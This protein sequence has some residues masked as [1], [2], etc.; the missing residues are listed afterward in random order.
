MV[1]HMHHPHPFLIPPSDSSISASRWE[2]A[3]EKFLELF[4]GKAPGLAHSDRTPLH[5]NQLDR[6]VKVSFDLAATILHDVTAPSSAASRDPRVPER[7]PSGRIVRPRTAELSREQRDRLNEFRELDEM[8]FIRPGTGGLRQGSANGRLWSQSSQYGDVVFPRTKRPLSRETK[9]LVFSILGDSFRCGLVPLIRGT[10][11]DATDKI[12][13]Q[14][15][16]HKQKLELEGVHHHLKHGVA[17]AAGPGLVDISINRG[18]NVFGVARSEVPARIPPNLTG[19]GV[20]KEYVDEGARRIIARNIVRRYQL[21]KLPQ[22]IRRMTPSPSKVGSLALEDGVERQFVRLSD[23]EG[24]SDR[25]MESDNEETRLQADKT[26]LR[27]RIDTSQIPQT[28]LFDFLGDMEE[29][30]AALGVTRADRQ[31]MQFQALQNGEQSDRLRTKGISV[32]HVFPLDYFMDEEDV[33]MI[34]SDLASRSSEEKLGYRAVMV[35]QDPNWVEIISHFLEL[36][37]T[38]CVVQDFDATTR[39]F[40]VKWDS[41]PR[42]PRGAADGTY[43]KSTA[44]VTRCQILRPTETAA[45]LR[46]K[47]L[48]A[49]HFRA[50]FEYHL[51]LRQCVGIVRPFI[52]PYLAAFPVSLVE[53]LFRESVRRVKCASRALS[54]TESCSLTSTRRRMV[55]HED[56]EE[57]EDSAI[58][59][60]ILIQLCNEVRNDYVRSQV[61]STLLHN[62]RFRAFLPSASLFDTGYRVPC[63]RHW[64]DSG[65]DESDPFP[66]EARV[67]VKVAAQFFEPAIGFVSPAVSSCLVWM[68]EELTA[69]FGLSLQEALRGPICRPPKLEEEAESLPENWEAAKMS[70]K[71]RKKSPKPARDSAKGAQKEEKKP[72]LRSRMSAAPVRPHARP[73]IKPLTSAVEVTENSELEESARQSRVDSGLIQALIDDETGRI[74]ISPRDFVDACVALQMD[75]ESSVHSRSAKIVADVFAS[76]RHLFD[77]HED[78]TAIT[79]A[80]S[81]EQRAEDVS[82]TDSSQFLTRLGKFVSALAES[83]IIPLVSGRIRESYNLF[84]EGLLRIRLE[85]VM[86]ETEDVPQDGSKVSDIEFNY[87]V[88]DVVPAVTAGLLGWLY[89]VECAL[90]DGALVSTP[91]D[92][93]FIETLFTELVKD[94]GEACKR[95][96]KDIKNTLSPRIISGS[97]ILPMGENAKEYVDDLER[98]LEDIKYVHD[99]ALWLSPQTERGIFEIDARGLISSVRHW[100]E[101]ARHRLLSTAVSNFTSQ[102]ATIITTCETYFSLPVAVTFEQART[103]KSVIREMRAAMPDIERRSEHIRRTKEFFDAHSL[104]LEDDC[105]AKYYRAYI[106]RDRMQTFLEEREDQL[107]RLVATLGVTL[108]REMEMFSELWKE[109]EANLEKL[110]TQQPLTKKHPETERT[111]PTG[112][113]NILK[114]ISNALDIATLIIQKAECIENFDRARMLQ[115]LCAF[116]ESRKQ[117]VTGLINLR[118][119]LEE[120]RSKPFS[121]VN[122]ET[123][124]H[125][126]QDILNAIEASNLLFSPV[127]VDARKELRLFMDAEL[128]V[129]RVLTNPKLRSWHWERVGEIIDKR[130][131]TFNET[132]LKEVVE[133]A[134]YR[135]LD[136]VTDELREVEEAA[137]KESAISTGLAD[138]TERFEAL[139]LDTTPNDAVG[140]T[141]IASFDMLISTIESDL[142]AINIMSSAQAVDNYTAAISALEKRL[143]FAL[144]VLKEWE[145]MQPLMINVHGFFDAEEVRLQ[146]AAELRRFR[147]V[148]GSYRALL[149]RTQKQ[150]NLSAVIE[151]ALDDLYQSLTEM[152]GVLQKVIDDVQGWLDNKRVVFPRLFFVTDDELLELVAVAKNPATVGHQLTKYFHFTEL[153]HKRDGS[154]RDYR[155]TGVKSLEGE[156]VAFRNFVTT[157]ALS[158]EVWLERVEHE[159][160]STL[161]EILF[162]ILRD[163]KSVKDGEKHQSKERHHSL[164]EDLPLSGVPGQMCL[165]AYQILTTSALER[166]ITGAPAISKEVAFQLRGTIQHLAALLRQQ[167]TTPQ[168]TTMWNS[169]I[170]HALHYRDWLQELQRKKITTVKS[171]DWLKGLRY[172]HDEDD[173]SVTVAQSLYSTSYGF[174][175]LGA[176]LKS[177]YTSQAKLVFPVAWTS[178]DAK[179]GVVAY[180][181]SASGKTEALRAYAKAIGKYTMLFPCGDSIPATVITR[182]MTGMA[183]ARSFVILQNLERLPPQAFSC[184]VGALAS[185][186]ELCKRKESALVS[187]MGRIVKLPVP[188]HIGSFATVNESHIKNMEFSQKLRLHM[189]LVAM[190]FPDL[191]IIAQASLHSAG[192][193]DAPSLGRKLG[194]LLELAPETLSH[195]S[196]YDFGLR[197]LKSILKLTQTVQ[198][199]HESKD[200]LRSLIKAIHLHISP[201][202]VQED[203]PIFSQLVVSVFGE[204]LPSSEDTSVN[205]RGTTSSLVSSIV[206]KKMAELKEV[207]EAGQHPLI[208]GPCGSGKTSLIRQSA[209]ALGATIHVVNPLAISDR[210]LFG[211]HESG[212]FVKGVLE[213][214]LGSSRLQERPKNWIVF[215]SPVSSRWTDLVSGMLEPQAGQSLCLAT[216]KRV[217]MNANTTVVVETETLETATHGI[218]G[219]FNVIYFRHQWEWRTYLESWLQGCLSQ[220]KLEYQ[221]AFLREAQDVKSCCE[222]Y[223]PAIFELV[224]NSGGHMSLQGLFRTCLDIL[225][226]LLLDSQHSLRSRIKD[227]GD[228]RIFAISND[229]FIF[230]LIWSFGCCLPADYR[231]RFED[232]LREKLPQMHPSCGLAKRLQN[233]SAESSSVFGLRFD[234][235]DGSWNSWADDSA[236]TF[237]Q[238]SM[239]LSM[240]HSR[241]V[242]SSLLLNHGKNVIFLGE[243]AARKTTTAMDLLTSRLEDDLVHVQPLIPDGGFEGIVSYLQ[244]VLVLDEESNHGVYVPPNGKRLIIFIDDMHVGSAEC[245]GDWEFLRSFLDLQGYWCS[246]RSFRST[247]QIAILGASDLLPNGDNV[248]PGRL[249]RHFAVIPFHEDDTIHGSTVKYYSQLMLNYLA[250]S[251]VSGVQAKMY[252]V[253]NA[254][255]DVYKSLKRRLLR[256]RETPFY[257]FTTHDLEKIYSTLLISAPECYENGSSTAKLWSYEIRRVFQDRMV[258]SDI[259]ILENA[260]HHLAQQY[261]NSVPDEKPGAYS[262]ITKERASIQENDASKSSFSIGAASFSTIIQSSTTQLASTGYVMRTQY[263]AID[264]TLLADVVTD[265]LQQREGGG[266][267]RHPALYAMGLEHFNRLDRILAQKRCG[268]GI[269][270]YPPSDSVSIDFV[271]LASSLRGFRYREFRLTGSSE[272]A[273]WSSLVRRQILDAAISQEQVLLHVIVVKNCQ[274]SKHIWK[275]LNS[276][277]DAGRVGHFWTQNE[278]D[279]LL[280]KIGSQLKKETEHRHNQSR[281]NSRNKGIVAATPGVGDQGKARDAQPARSNLEFMRSLGDRISR[282]L[283]II[284]SFSSDDC[285]NME[286]L[287][288]FPR[289]IARSTL[290]I[291]SELTE[292]GLTDMAMGHLRNG[293]FL[294]VKTSNYSERTSICCARLYIAA[295][296]AYRGLQEGAQYPQ[297]HHF[298]QFLT[299]LSDDYME[300]SLSVHQLKEDYISCLSKLIDAKASITSLVQN[301]KVQL[302]NLPAQLKSTIAELNTVTEMMGPK[303]AS[304]RNLTLTLRNKE[305]SAKRAL[306]EKEEQLASQSVEAAR[307]NFEQSLR[308]LHALR[309][310][311]IEE[312][313]GFSS[314]PPLLELLGNA[315]CIIFDRAAS[316]QEARKLFASHSF[317]QRVVSLDLKSLTELKV[318]KLRKTIEVPLFHPDRLTSAIPAVRALCIWVKATCQYTKELRRERMDVQ[319]VHKT[320]ASSDLRVAKADP[321]RVDLDNAIAELEDLEKRQAQLTDEKRE[322]VGRSALFQEIFS[323][324]SIFDSHAVGEVDHVSESQWIQQ[325]FHCADDGV[326]FED[327]AVAFAHEKYRHALDNLTN[328]RENMTKDLMEANAYLESAE[329]LSASITMGEIDELIAQSATNSFA[330][331]AKA[332]MSQMLKMRAP[333]EAE[334][335]HATL[336][337][338]DLEQISSSNG[339]ILKSLVHDPSF[340]HSPFYDLRSAT[341]TAMEPFH[342]CRAAFVI[343]DMISA[344]HMYHVKRERVTE[345]LHLA[346]KEVTEKKRIFDRLW[347]EKYAHL[348]EYW[349][350]ERIVQALKDSRDRL[351]GADVELMKSDLTAGNISNILKSIIKASCALIGWNGDFALLAKWI[352]RNPQRFLKELGVVKVANARVMEVIQSHLPAG[353]DLN[354]LAELVK[355]QYSRMYVDAVQYL[356]RQISMIILRLLDDKSLGRAAQN[357]DWRYL[358]TK[359]VSCHQTRLD[360][361]EKAFLNDI[362]GTIGIKAYKKVSAFLKKIPE[363][364]A[365][366]Q[367]RPDSTS[368]ADDALHLEFVNIIFMKI[369][370]AFSTYLANEAIAAGHRE[371][372]ARQTVEKN[373]SLRH[374]KAVV[375]PKCSNGSTL[376]SIMVH[377][378]VL[379]RGRK[380]GLLHPA[381]DKLRKQLHHG[382]VSTT[383]ILDFVMPRAPVDTR[384]DPPLAIPIP[385]NIG[386]S[387]FLM[388]AQYMETVYAYHHGR[389]MGKYLQFQDRFVKSLQQLSDKLQCNIDNLARQEQSLLGHLLYDLSIL[390]YAGGL[391]ASKRKEFREKC[392]VVVNTSFDESWKFDLFNEYPVV[393]ETNSALLSTLFVRENLAIASFV[394]RDILLIDPSD[395]GK[396]ALN[397]LNEFEG[398]RLCEDAEV[399]KANQP[400]ISPKLDILLSRDIPVV[401]EH[402]NTPQQFEDIV[403]T[404]EKHA[405]PRRAEFANM[406]KLSEKS[407]DD[408]VSMMKTSMI[409]ESDELMHDIILLQRKTVEVVSLKAKVTA[410][411]LEATPQYEPYNR[412]ID[413]ACELYTVTDRLEALHFL[414]H[415]SVQLFVAVFE[416]VYKAANTNSEKD[417]NR[418][419]LHYIASV[420][421]SEFG[422]TVSQGMNGE[423]K[424]L[425]LFTVGMIYLKFTGELKAKDLD[426]LEDLLFECNQRDPVEF[427]QWLAHSFSHKLDDRP[428][429]LEAIQ[430][431]LRTPYGSYIADI[432]LNALE[433]RLTEYQKALIQLIFHPHSLVTGAVDGLLRHA[434]LHINMNEAF[435]DVL[436]ALRTQKHSRYLI[437]T[438]SSGAA[439]R[440]IQDLFEQDTS[441]SQL[442]MLEEA[443]KQLELQWREK[444]RYAA[445]SGDWVIITI[446]E[447]FAAQLTTVY[448]IIEGAA[449]GFALWLICPTYAEYLLPTWM[450]GECRCVFQELPSDPSHLAGQLCH[451]VALPDMGQTATMGLEVF[452]IVHFHVSLL[453]ISGLSNYVSADDADLDI[454]LRILRAA[455]QTGITTQSIDEVLLGATYLKE[456]PQGFERSQVEAVWRSSLAICRKTV[457]NVDFDKFTTQTLS[458]EFLQLGVQLFSDI[459]AIRQSSLNE[460]QRSMA[461]EFCRKISRLLQP[462]RDSV[463]GAMRTSTIKRKISWCLG[464]LPLELR[465]R[466]L[467]ER[468]HVTSDILALLLLEETSGLTTLCRHIRAR[469]QTLWSSLTNGH[470]ILTGQK[471]LKSFQSKNAST[472]FH[473]H[474][475]DDFNYTRWTL[476]AATSIRALLS[477]PTTGRAIL[478]ISASKVL[479]LPALINGRLMKEAINRETTIDFVEGVFEPIARQTVLD[480]KEK[481]QKYIIV[482]DT[483]IHNVHLQ[484]AEVHAL[485]IGTA[486]SLPALALKFFGSEKGMEEFGTAAA[487]EKLVKDNV[488]SRGEYSCPILIGDS[489]KALRWNIELSTLIPSE[490]LFKV[491]VTAS[492]SD[493]SVVLS[494]KRPSGLTAVL[495]LSGRARKFPVTDRGAAHQLTVYICSTDDAQNELEYLLNVVVPSLQRDLMVHQIDLHVLDMKQGSSTPTVTATDYARAACSQ[496]QRSAIFVGLLGAQLGE[497][498]DVHLPTN[499]TG[500]VTALTLTEMEIEFALSI[501]GGNQC[502]FYFRDPAFSRSVP[503]SFRSKYE[504]EN[505]DDSGRLATLKEN[506]AHAH[507]SRVCLDYPCFFSRIEA[508]KVKMGGLESLG[509]RLRTDISAAAMDF[510]KTT[511]RHQ[512][513]G[514]EYV[515]TS[516]DCHFER[517]DCI[518]GVLTEEDGELGICED[519]RSAPATSLLICGDTG[520][521]KSTL[522]ARLCRDYEKRGFI[523]VANFVRTWLGSFSTHRMLRRFCKTLRAEIGEPP[524]DP[525]RE[526]DLLLTYFE[527]TL[528]DVVGRGEKV[529]FV[530]D[531]LDRLT[532]GYTKQDNLHWLPPFAHTNTEMLRQTRWLFSAKPNSDLL[533]AL[534]QKHPTAQALNLKSWSVNDC[535]GLID[536]LSRSQHLILPTKPMS[537]LLEREDLRT[538]LFLSLVVEEAQHSAI[539]GRIASADGTVPG[540]QILFDQIL[541]RLEQQHGLDTIKLL[542]ELVTTARAGLL[543]CELVRLL[544]ISLV[545]WNLI[546]DVVRR[547]LVMAE[548]ERYIPF[549]EH[550]T[551]ALRSRYMSDVKEVKKV[552]KMLAEYYLGVSD[553]D[554]SRKWAGRRKERVPDIVYHLFACDAKAATVA[555]VMCSLRFVEIVFAVGMDYELPANFSRLLQ[556][557]QS[558]GDETLVTKAS[559]YGLFIHQNAHHLYENPK[560]TFPLAYNLQGS[561]ETVRQ[562]AIKCCTERQIQES[563]LEVLAPRGNH[564]EAVTLGYHPSTIVALSIKNVAS[565]G[566][567]CLSVS[568]DATVKAWDMDTFSPIG[569][570]MEAQL[571]AG[572]V[573][574]CCFSLNGAEKMALALCNRDIHVYDLKGKVLIATIE[575]RYNGGLMFFGESDSGVWQ[576][577]SKKQLEWIDFARSTSQNMSG[578][579]PGSSDEQTTDVPSEAYEVEE[580]VQGMPPQSTASTDQKDMLKG[581]CDDIIARSLDGLK[582]AF[583]SSRRKSIIVFNTLRMREICRFSDDMLERVSFGAFSMGKDLLA[584]AHSGGEIMT[585]KIDNHSRVSLIRLTD[586][587][588]QSLGFSIDEASLFVGCSDST[589]AVVNLASGQIGKSFHVG[590]GALQHLCTATSNGK[591]RVFLSSGS[592]VMVCDSRIGLKGDRS[593]STQDRSLVYQRHDQAVNRTDVVYGHWGDREAHVLSSSCDGT[594]IIWTIDPTTQSVLPY[595]TIQLPSPLHWFQVCEPEG[596]LACAAASECIVWDLHKHSESLRFT[597]ETTVRRAFL[598]HRASG[599]RS[600]TLFVW[601]WDGILTSWDVSRVDRALSIS[602]SPMYTRPVTLLPPHALSLNESWLI[603]GHHHRVSV[604]DAET[605]A[606]MQSF[607][608]LDGDP[609]LDAQWARPLTSKSQPIL[610]CSASTMLLDANIMSYGGSGGDTIQLRSCQYDWASHRAAYAATCIDYA[611]ATEIK[612][613]IVQVMEGGA[614]PGRRCTLRHPNAQVVAWAFMHDPRFIVTAASDRMVRVWDLDKSFAT[615]GRGMGGALGLESEEGEGGDVQVGFGVV[616]ALFPTRGRPKSLAVGRDKLMVFVGDEYGEMVA[617][618]LRLAG[619]ING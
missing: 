549:H 15:A 362:S 94:G 496:I 444:L 520:V 465:T 594:I 269:L 433:H 458:K 585:W 222:L 81:L 316:W 375:I 140:L 168:V 128:P 398:G 291:H 547:Y 208:L 485:S 139:V 11:A 161:R 23:E 124:S 280:A 314:P 401:V 533:R 356:P 538:P 459:F 205:A 351:M 311:D 20:P 310:D 427:F 464:A 109:V 130:G 272:P 279:D 174:E 187:F 605:G 413:F 288:E 472:H 220:I 468:R 176:D 160:Q 179:L 197:T 388:L 155:I 358:Y 384:K 506:L 553:P 92:H 555:S 566:K 504:P 274:D 141:V 239:H 32:G 383:V 224:E 445:M 327:D 449:T 302:Q 543:E 392:E 609:V 582:I 29:T 395:L 410:F 1:E 432:N 299:M 189:R 204:H 536:K 345:T 336:R 251:G 440:A 540:M 434:N 281:V 210:V 221:A 76:L 374:R 62:P 378:L 399:L 513:N 242:I 104:S 9:Q 350:F 216:G 332:A 475:D 212:G 587:G 72:P 419:R 390:V 48:E 420:F 479:S 213:N 575:D 59:S 407:F 466:S 185:L 577:G 602:A 301:T 360:T 541:T 115:D 560:L 137:E 512:P 164:Y 64:Q 570:V 339:Q 170:A 231:N 277:L 568:D 200:E 405:R 355:T 270:L 604:I 610:F 342:A 303:R 528:R 359:L 503:K 363:F 497:K 482:T 338:A 135:N 244:R 354:R 331:N 22:G 248:L 3:E 284:V 28:T 125:S 492:Y 278:F 517:T 33:R 320:K 65:V 6:P 372:T 502:F 192:F 173:M 527:E 158:V 43:S 462:P 283:K 400:D 312:I 17:P 114:H 300:K 203:M 589:I 583:T 364:T 121:K 545:Q 514:C 379:D 572:T 102:I 525:P 421:A 261:F 143:S 598:G 386:N 178:L 113:G 317:V 397:R 490:T 387:L 412:L 426:I 38:P 18:E 4:F 371:L 424:A 498:V 133:A 394:A 119:N 508:K 469:L 147:G 254:T 56:E 393:S 554:G 154:A 132:S 247:R 68:R 556:L 90:P 451:G 476:E 615:C 607:E 484:N 292:E 82:T 134:G 266:H 406:S 396:D 443:D 404:Y 152:R 75:F 100:A 483:Y 370:Q 229:A 361:L 446:D 552:H 452:T 600:L 532:G 186:R 461:R 608:S 591:Q 544:K 183:M 522:L 344:M 450:R 51:T 474:L 349:S 318:E 287:L 233:L 494:A 117:M 507:P 26:S 7:S 209:A 93:R 136:I 263:R 66:Q 322:L 579:G 257:L 86:A 580:D 107:Q 225:E 417:M 275:D 455:A 252:A 382:R 307:V 131:V 206:E 548:L 341:L 578:D 79:G 230:A 367:I 60:M 495:P 227:L 422:H 408:I 235:V 123:V 97:S 223:L 167:T 27:K 282:N 267:L 95:Y 157:K 486:H 619:S 258:C 52:E 471:N 73:L 616:C 597:T 49:Q 99:H 30:M 42:R 53:R 477:H 431:G 481:C 25:R 219:T 41:A 63:G 21:P 526:Y 153:I 218:A 211:Y 385:P 142:L 489:K 16:V 564:V 8:V 180:G 366:E 614:G 250:S 172:T 255:V 57:D 437:I 328:C 198:Q 535:Q 325:A 428:G 296:E 586:L 329:T 126:A 439:Q 368:R 243:L 581:I 191:K 346:E 144:S 539:C 416:N 596:Y 44:W 376:E 265:Y 473:Q 294:G 12:E 194:L 305:E 151:T 169:F 389:R 308:T 333:I 58:P 606:E 493:A 521:G 613:G 182:I 260:L 84:K 36:E 2:L 39:R 166:A 215:D 487:D 184:Y 276:L 50:E 457:E 271:R 357:M 71:G 238:S 146:L 442:C 353:C 409:I 546:F 245:Q 588:V 91:A 453:Y 550:L 201:K 347:S 343:R 295:K 237:S 285:R 195:R 232:A 448:Q 537:S 323:A 467:F 190:P 259:S 246:S 214:L 381:V 46:L 309:K 262:D 148:E 163:F 122:V 571:A 590:G 240:V 601:T 340:H 557:A 337:N 524:R 391:P 478:N 584:V 529:V 70:S 5:P 365:L 14:W 330:E 298:E 418:E 402:L 253:I 234:P 369:E 617:F 85:L 377:E 574:E 217:F 156:S 411:E 67:S 268:F 88:D 510:L 438:W 145:I 611:G 256:S 425:F 326:L 55:E 289:I 319:N 19:P 129:L 515:G 127:V 236:A 96:L 83:Y 149:T 569:T 592:R 34:C 542:F 37:W 324:T 13:R 77:L 226:C 334:A 559:D 177:P 112:L 304:I 273:A 35:G 463:V 447:Y 423:N 108:E 593:A 159:V 491:G 171:Y 241:H 558:E 501:H 511:S 499:R 228:D 105:V 523:V 116:M 45:G 315:I 505:A 89:P 24:V 74:S 31:V 373:A 415:V 348:P 162:S 430:K 175:Y 530:I 456:T 111:P 454:S 297:L 561:L 509:Q 103:A 335:F 565:Y 54:H 306:Q 40:L 196:H 603:V 531:G 120:W 436:K 480:S 313:K 101:L 567:C 534:R 264:L 595:K 138:I 551:A 47:L 61:Q 460:R 414:D 110:F 562:E 380:A 518:D 488:D 441:S 576:R 599:G 618:R 612:Y 519:E 500:P 150:R 181:P 98:V 118:H 207:V 165:L 199:T 80:E 286:E 202:L 106:L 516:I 87:A 193:T 435:D 293:N 563:F 249:L 352:M 10:A 321:E 429:L 188:V 573:E 69:S 78:N 290:D 470:Q 403:R